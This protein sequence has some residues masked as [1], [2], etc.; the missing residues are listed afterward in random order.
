MFIGHF[1][2]FFGKTSIPILWPLSPS[3]FLLL[4]RRRPPVLATPPWPVHGLQTPAPGRRCPV[5][6]VGSGLWHT[7]IY[8]LDVI[9]FIY[10]FLWLPEIL[11]VLAFKSSPVPPPRTPVLRLSA[12]P[13]SI[14]GRPSVE[15]PRPPGTSPLTGPRWSKCPVVFLRTRY[16]L[17][18]QY[19]FNCNCSHVRV[20]PTNPHTLATGL[21][22]PSG[23][24]LH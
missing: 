23:R 14:N 12:G 1:C 16:F 2:I 8:N 11:S 20:P 9:Q 10:S 5:R 24:E 7:H 18:S 19:L 15:M 21:P 22:V 13:A 17:R 3:G 4:T 6:W